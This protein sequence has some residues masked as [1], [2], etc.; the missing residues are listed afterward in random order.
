MQPGLIL[1]IKWNEEAAFRIFVSKIC[2]EPRG[3]TFMYLYVYRF[4]HNFAIT[5]QNQLCANIFLLIS[6]PPQSLML[7]FEESNSEK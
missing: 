5:Y 7:M 3:R 1:I 2:R 6:I 4:E